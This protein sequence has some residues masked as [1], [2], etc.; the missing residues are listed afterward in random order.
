M[1]RSDRLL[2]LLAGIAAV[3]T[4]C[5][6]APAADYRVSIA[7][8]SP[9]ALRV[10]IDLRGVPRDSLTLRGFAAKEVLRISNL[11]A[12]GPGGAALPVEAGLETVSVNGRSVDLPRLTLRGPLPGSITVRYTASPGN[13]EGDSHM[14][15]T[16]RCHG[17][18]GD[19]FGFVTGR[20]VF[21]LPEPVEKVERIAVRFALPDG[22]TAVV[23]WR[24]DG[25]LWR[26][27]VDGRLA[28]EHLV[29]SAIGLGRFRER[30]FEVGATRYRL[31]FE[32]GVTPPEEAEA[33]ARLETVARYLRGLFGHDLG[34]EYLTVVVP[35]ALTRDEIVGEGWATGQ[36]QTLAPMTGNRLHQFADQLIDAYL[37][38]A[39]Y[40]SE[41]QDP[42]EFWLVDGLKNL[43]GWRALDAAGLVPEEALR[44]ELAVGYLIALNVH[45]LQRDL[46][47]LYSAPGS[48][49]TERESLAPFV[50]AYLDHEIRAATKNASSLDAVVATMFRGR[51]AGSLWS[52]LPPPGPVSWERFRERYVRGGA[53][54]VPVEQFYSVAPTRPSPEP[55]AGKPVRALTIVY[56]GKTNGYL[57]NCGCKV[58]QSGGVA[59]RATALAA[60]RRSEPQAV[61][62]DAGSAFLMPEKQQ[63][64]DYLSRAETALYLKT[65]KMMRYQAVAVGAT[66]LTFG[67]DHF[68][69][70]LRGL[71]IPY[72]AAN[73]RDGDRPVAPP[74]TIVNAAGLRLGVIGVFEAPWGR[75]ATPSFEEASAPLRIDDPVET[76]RREVP[77][78]EKR[79]DLV[80]AIGRLTPA[81]IRRAVEASPGL[82]LIVS[83]EYDSP[84]HGDGRDEDLH[85]EDHEGFVGRTLVAYTHLTNYG[86]GSVRL[87]LDAQGR[88]ATAAFSDHWLYE[89]VPDQRQVRDLLNRFY[90]DV[91]RRAAA[92][93]SVPPLFADDPER[94]N[95]RYAGA[96][97][98]ATCHQAEHDQWMTTKHA[99]AYKTL[100]DRHRHF[101]PKCVSC[102]VV[103]YGTPN[104]YRL[105]MPEQTLANVQCEVCH[106]PGAEHA[107]DPKAANIHRQVPEKVCLECHNPEH[108]DH[109]V[110]AERL[111]KV[112]HDYVE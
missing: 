46:E 79:A 87:G 66:E 63:A 102:H 91:G 59:R 22:W 112:R 6:R 72:L 26:P 53:D 35:K 75:A 107:R 74:T 67:L 56:T 83:T 58:N 94:L 93:E 24:R 65:M 27:G 76:L 20:M 50:L 61:L 100:L 40:R 7:A 33:A 32:S 90:D 28:G 89:D 43:Y 70:A 92:Q 39:P 11:D 13:R 36:G 98:C 106:G 8:E 77:A 23:P 42:G 62:L 85:K 30:S 18:V 54:L 82:D 86:L 105:G 44:R 25:D 47:R 2:A 29:A 95:G 17:Y 51:R 52:S 81:T 38:H 111:P 21:L 5:A 88:I 109:F 37:R 108:S 34:P 4:G 101:Q 60:I 10:E 55:P 68:R 80:C 16:G 15:F 84:T 110:Y 104:G 96:A 78:L 73:V 48:H 9:G 49:R 19:D 1:P 103:G 14:G 71:A 99:S 45:G 69:E 12:A 31:A 64:L 41:I 57:E 3:G 97:R